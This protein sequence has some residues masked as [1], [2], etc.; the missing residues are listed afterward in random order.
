MWKHALHH[1]NPVRILPIPFDNETTAIG[2][3]CPQKKHFS[4]C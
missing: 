2:G 1:P 3:G 4:F